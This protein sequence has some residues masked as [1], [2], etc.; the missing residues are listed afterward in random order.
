MWYGFVGFFYEIKGLLMYVS[1]PVYFFFFL[2]WRFYVNAV[3]DKSDCKRRFVVPE[4]VGILSFVVGY[5]L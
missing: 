4:M 5:C 2:L 1:V 3:R